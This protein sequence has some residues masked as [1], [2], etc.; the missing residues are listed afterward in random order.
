MTLSDEKV[1]YAVFFL[2]QHSSWDPTAVIIMGAFWRSLHK[3]QHSI[4]LF[5]FFGGYPWDTRLL[6]QQTQDPSLCTTSFTHWVCR[7]FLQ[8]QLSF[9]AGLQ[10]GGFFLPIYLLS[11]SSH[12]TSPCHLPLLL[13][14]CKISFPPTNPHLFYISSLVPHSV[15][16]RWS[17]TSL[18][19]F[20]FPKS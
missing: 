17:I 18:P 16:H 1:Q 12:S 7:C 13:P 9:K 10:W 19:L 5:L 15:Y 3:A 2:P 8:T 6:L 14:F 4:P 20:F 11:N